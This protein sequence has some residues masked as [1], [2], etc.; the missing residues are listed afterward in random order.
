MRIFSGIAPSGI[1]HIGNYL[2]A[3]KNWLGLQKKHQCIF[4]VVDHHAITLPQDPQKLRAKI[5]EIAAI[6]LSAGVDTKKSTIF[7]QSDL[8]AHTELAWI[9][10]TITKIGEL[11]RMTQFKERAKLHPAQVNVA[12]FDYPVLMAADIL[13]YQT[14]IVPV[15]EDQ[16]QH[17]ELARTLARRFNRLYGKTFTTPKVLIQ[18]Q[19]ARIMGL[20]DPLKKM[21]K[22]AVNPLNFIALTD[23]PSTIRQ[24]IKRAVTDSG[25]EIE[26]SPKKPA[27]SNLLTIYSL[28]SG[29]SIKD[30]EEKYKNSGYALFKK[31]LAEELIG[32]LSPF[33]KRFN[34]LIKKPNHIKKILA[35]GAKKARPI[36][37]RTLK[38]VKKKIGLV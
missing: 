15:G 30:L 27:I 37:E 32:F 9:L 34:S 7:V 2:G 16:A 38:E 1:I 11:K 23:S 31:D 33:Q 26:L 5:L 28:V 13:L 24:K 35:Q 22:S 29:K 19:G 8:G 21:S 14:N 6:Y 4:C 12:L 36:A 17:V 10:S 3:I 20:D 18:K 25:R